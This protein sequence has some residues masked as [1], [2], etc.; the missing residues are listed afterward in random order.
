MVELEYEDSSEYYYTPSYWY[1]Y[2]VFDSQECDCILSNDQL[3]DMEAE[4][5]EGPLAEPP[6]WMGVD[7]ESLDKKLNYRDW[8]MSH[9]PEEVPWN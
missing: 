5:T 2:A 4:L 1:P 9:W 3:A 8:W 7:P 6:G